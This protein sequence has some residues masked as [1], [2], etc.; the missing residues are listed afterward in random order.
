MD[1]LLKFIKDGTISNVLENVGKIANV[2]NPALGSGLM[3][4]SNITDN[5]KGVSDEFLE[6]DV[7]GVSGTASR[8]R[9]MVESDHYDKELLLILCDNLDSISEFVQKTSKLIK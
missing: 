6:N 4:A 7:I 9:K 3:L 5:T 1:E 2:F 8:I